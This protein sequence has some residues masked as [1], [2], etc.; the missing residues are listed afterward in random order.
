MAVTLWGQIDW[1]C[2]RDAEGHR[3]YKVIWRVK[4]DVTDGPANVLRTPGLPVVGSLWGFGSD[5]DLWAWCR[6]N[7]TVRRHDAKEGDQHRWWTVEQTFATKPPDR[8]QQ[9]CGDVE[10]TDPLLEPPKISGSFV[11]YTEEASYDRFGLPITSSSWEPVRGPAVEFDA[12]RMRV[13]IELNTVASIFP[14][15]SAAY[16]TV[17]ASPL[18]GLPARCVKLS[19]A[20]FERKFFAMCY[21]YYTWSFDF[22]IRHDGFDRD[23]LDEGTKVLRGKWNTA[24]NEWQLTRDGDGSLPDNTNPAHFIRFVDI[25]GNTTRTLLNGAGLPAET[26]IETGTGTGTGTGGSVTSGTGQIHIEK[27]NESNFLLLGIP[28]SF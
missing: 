22:D 13:H 3:E 18:W 8:N 20:S 25:H 4:S 2:T 9:R 16:Q 11:N 15:V 12:G 23:I 10:I 24:N 17:N 26:A 19:E 7:A 27:Y 14:L 6:P 5:F 21:L 1:T 28:T